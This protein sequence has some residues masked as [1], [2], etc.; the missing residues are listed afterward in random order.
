M[1][2]TY[3]ELETK[4]QRTEGIL[5]RALDEIAKLHGESSK[6]KSTAIQRIALNPLYRSE[7]Q[8]L[9]ESEK[10]QRAKSWQGS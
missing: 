5:A 1:K 9:R 8:Y 4:L 2:L 7:K 6:S 10:T 3:Q